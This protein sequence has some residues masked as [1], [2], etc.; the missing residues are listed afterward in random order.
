MIN[1]ICKP[2]QDN[3]FISNN[4][5]GKVDQMI[6]V[7]NNRLEELLSNPSESGRRTQQGSE[8]LTLSF[9]KDFHWKPE[10]NKGRQNK[11]STLVLD[12]KTIPSKLCCANEDS[13]YYSQKDE[14][15][16]NNSNQNNTRIKD[17]RNAA[18]Q[19]NCENHVG[20]ECPKEEHTYPEDQL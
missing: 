13:C 6:F 2:T 15:H 20:E 14:N 3:T 19:N 17:S 11:G 1:K 8:L 5:T 12:S 7:L 18:P 9:I 4:S 16:K 10:Q